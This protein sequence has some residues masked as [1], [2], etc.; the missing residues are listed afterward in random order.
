MRR[1][2]PR[3]RGGGSCTSIIQRFITSSTRHTLFVPRVAHAS[4]VAGNL[5]STD[6][7]VRGSTP[8]EAR[9]GG[10]HDCLVHG[11][12]DGDAHGRLL[13]VVVLLRRRLRPTPPGSQ[14]RGVDMA[15][16]GAR[17]RAEE[18]VSADAGIAV[19][20]LVVQLALREP[21][22]QQPGRRGEDDAHHD[23]DINAPHAVARRVAWTRCEWRRGRE[24]SE[25]RG[26]GVPIY[27][28]VPTQCELMNRTV[29]IHMPADVSTASSALYME[30]TSRPRRLPA[31]HLHPLPS[32]SPPPSPLFPRP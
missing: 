21:R 26:R 16:W 9:G 13:R 29:S 10:V 7:D 30:I 8:S 2:I 20:P 15:R 32:F 4:R 5:L 25:R 14:A 31:R 11:W 24:I 1:G 18:V 27:F 17:G 6:V 19:G 12:L 3:S 22:V 28:G 23:G